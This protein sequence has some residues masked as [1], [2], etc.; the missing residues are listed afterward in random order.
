VTATI[1][2]TRDAPRLFRKPA[3]PCNEPAPGF[4]SQ[5]D[6]A[7]IA[8]G[9][10]SIWLT[11]VKGAKGIVAHEK[12]GSRN[13]ADFQKI[14]GVRAPDAAQRVALAK[15]CAADPGSSLLA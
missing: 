1:A 7:I 12:I 11:K 3:K 10:V 15:R 2:I 4:G 6:W 13:E 14:A 8:Y 9:M 5:A